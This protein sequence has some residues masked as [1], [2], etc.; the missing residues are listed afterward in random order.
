MVLGGSGHTHTHTH[1]QGGREGG[2]GREEG[3][4]EREPATGRMEK[5]PNTKC[6]PSSQKVGH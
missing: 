5:I 4:G 3:E 1:T 2:R 6:K